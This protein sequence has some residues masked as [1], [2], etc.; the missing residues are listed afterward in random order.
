MKTVTGGFLY[1]L[2]D[3]VDERCALRSFCDTDRICQMPA[4]RWAQGNGAQ[5]AEYVFLFNQLLGA[6]PRRCGLVYNRDFRRE[7]FPRQD[8]TEKVFRE[9]WFNI[10]TGRPGRPRTVAKYYEYGLLRFWRHLAVNLSFRPIG[11]SWFL[12][13]V[14]KYFFTTDGETPCDPDLVGPYTTGI[15]AVE[16]NHHVLNH[17]LFW[18]DII[19][20]QKPVIRLSLFYKTATVIEKEPTLGIANFAIPNDPAVYDDEPETE[21]SL[22]PMPAPAEDEGESDEY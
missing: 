16:H 19:S 11:S 18:T 6:H 13:V 15:K 3:L 21:P 10:R 2:A 12:Q 22:F 17:V 14:P 9:D 1:T 5:R 20:Q 4:A 7:Y 8:E